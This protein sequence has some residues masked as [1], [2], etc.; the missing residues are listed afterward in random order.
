MGVNFEELDHRDTALGELSLRRRRIPSLGEGD[1]YEVK[2]GEEF[3]MSSLF[4]AVEVA[5][6]TLGLAAVAGDAL[7]V[8]VGGLGLGYTA[9]AALDEP[10]VEALL[11]IDFLAPVIEWHRAGLVPLGRELTDDPRCRFVHADF[12]AQVRSPGLDPENP[13]RRF[14]A[15]LLD[16]DHTP[17]HVLHPSHAALYAPDGLKNLARHL[18]PGG[19][20]AMW[21]DAPAD[22]AYLQALGKIFGEVEARTVTFFNPLQERESASIVY[23]ARNPIA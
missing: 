3:L 17:R 12:F 21:S 4:H 19:I 9:R 10:R 7:D 23:L 8:V 6:A 13:A 15:I 20:F 2:L 22:E 18:R 14:H 11:V 16:I 1:I 5:L